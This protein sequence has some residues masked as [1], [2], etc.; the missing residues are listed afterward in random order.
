SNVTNV[1][2]PS[3]LL[4]VNTESLGTTPAAAAFCTDFAS[5]PVSVDVFGTDYSLVEAGGGT[6]ESYQES[7]FVTEGFWEQLLE[8]ED[9]DDEE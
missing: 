4:T 8:D 7:P 9:E 3:S 1:V 2:N 5:C 6:G